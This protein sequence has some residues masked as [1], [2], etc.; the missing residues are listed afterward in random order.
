MCCPFPINGFCGRIEKPWRADH[1][2]K[3]EIC[4]TFDNNE[5]VKATLKLDFNRFGLV[6]ECNEQSQEW[7]SQLA[8]YRIAYLPVFSAFLAQEERRT[9]AII[10]DELARGRVH[11]VIRN[12]LLDLKSQNRHEELVQT[13]QRSFPTLSKMRI[14][15]DQVSDRYI[16]VAYQES[17]RPKEFDVFSAGSGFQQFLYLFGFIYL[18]KPAV[19][20]LDEPD[21]HLHGILQNAL[22]RELQLLV[23]DGKQILFATHSR[24]LIQGISPEHII[25]L[26]Q[27]K[28]KRLTILYD[29]YDI[30]DEL[31]SV[32]PTQ[33]P[34]IQAYQRVLIIEDRADWELLSI[35]CSMCL[36]QAR[37]QELV[38][39]LAICYSKGNPRNQDVKRLRDQLQQLITLE[40]KTLKAFVVADR[41]YYPDLDHLQSGCP[42]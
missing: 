22:L 42:I 28:A 19:I 21:V 37:W 35:F 9:A 15:F 7:L 13:L 29:V 14:E 31:G 24:D 8:D 6:V 5:K 23:S 11:S 41:D 32:D 2:K 33:L 16:S 38:K 27:E 20:L 1:K 4:V 30:L 39:R 40:G 10:E 18:R 36:G 3:I 26:E 12:L 34:I 25:S 17:G